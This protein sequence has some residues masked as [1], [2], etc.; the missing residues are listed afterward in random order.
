MIPE[1]QILLRLYH[2]QELLEEAERNR[3]FRIATNG[4]P[5]FNL[6]RLGLAYLGKVFIWLG[7]RLE[8]QNDG[9]RLE[10]ADRSC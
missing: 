1:S 4:E 3:L 7:T 6:V 5:G 2:N 10:T 9:Y 8:A